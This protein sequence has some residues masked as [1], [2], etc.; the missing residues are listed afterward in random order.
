MTATLS[1]SNGKQQERLLAQTSLTFSGWGMGFGIAIA[2]MSLGVGILGH[3][4]LTARAI[5]NQNPLKFLE[6]VEPFNFSVKAKEQ[7]DGMAWKVETDRGTYT[8]GLKVDPY[9]EEFELY[10]NFVDK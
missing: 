8:G 1:K 6:Q 2:G 9:G 3:G 10:G 7:S 4:Y 5:E